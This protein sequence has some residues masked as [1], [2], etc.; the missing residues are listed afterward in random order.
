MLAQLSCCSGFLPGITGASELSSVLLVAIGTAFSIRQS[1]ALNRDC[2]ATEVGSHDELMA[3]GG[4][5][6][7]LYEIQAAAYR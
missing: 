3:A 5:Y 4:K 7:E 6:A 1:A 2:W